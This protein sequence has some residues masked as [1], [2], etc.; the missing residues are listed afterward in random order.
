[1]SERQDLDFRLPALRARDVIAATLQAAFSS[2]DLFGSGKPQPYL[3]NLNDP[4]GSRIW[5]SSG[6]GRTESSQRDARRIQISVT[7]GEYAPQDAHQHNF[8]SLSFSSGTR[9]FTDAG[10]CAIMVNCEAGTEIES[11]TVASICYQI[12]KLFRQQIMADFDIF[13]LRIAGISPAMK[14][15]DS[16]GKP[17]MT[18]VT[19]QVVTQ[20]HARMAEIGN[21]L[22]RL[23]IQSHMTAVAETLPVVQLDATPT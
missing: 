11:E 5:I 7:R 20:E 6:A 16:P 12:L 9:E 14:F 8:A 23:D 18:S 21:A 22:N 1:M 2:P 10:A 3:L 15:E 17:F 13:N 4:Q 19:V